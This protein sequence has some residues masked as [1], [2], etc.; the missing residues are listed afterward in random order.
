MMTEKRFSLCPHCRH[1]KIKFF[2]G[3]VIF[4]TYLTKQWD[5]I[6]FLQNYDKFDI[7]QISKQLL[8]QKKYK[9]EI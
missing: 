8:T 3:Q 5:N 9:Y 6:F 1:R 7:L 2:K 4:F